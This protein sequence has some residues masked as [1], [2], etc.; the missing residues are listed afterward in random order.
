MS[1]ARCWLVGLAAVALLLQAAPAQ[2]CGGGVAR[3]FVGI[4]GQRV[5]FSV[6]K[7]STEAVLEL[8]VPE[9]PGDWG[10][11]LPV[12]VEPTLDPDPVPTSEID[13]FDAFTQV[14][15]ESD[16]YGGCGCGAGAGDPGGD[17]KGVRASEP[18]DIG[19]VTATVLAAD[20][21][22]SLTAWLDENGFVVPAEEQPIVDEYVTTQ[23]RFVVFKRSQASEPGSASRVGVHMTLPGDH[24]MYPLRISR[25][26][27]AP[28]L[29]ITLWIAASEPVAP[30][31]P[32]VL[33]EADDLLK[34]TDPYRTAVV[35]AVADAGGHAFVREGLFDRDTLAEQDGVYD[36]FYYTSVLGPRLAALLDPG[37]RITRFSTVIDRTQL[38][39]DAMFEAAPE[40]ASASML[41]PLPRG[42]DLTPWLLGLGVVAGWLRACGA[43]FVTRGLG[44]RR[45]P[46]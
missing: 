18:V 11:I 38:D 15:H 33:L 3:E 27:A 41:A 45:E 30:A 39:T 13:R 35:R 12:P 17:S 24:R 25:V 44:G 16:A 22:S 46:R 1:G 28:E 8:S 43:R 14:A 6:R 31:D 19:P 20:D 4:S 9:A 5:L 21:G 10:V 34:E 2:A 23:T 7:D 37:Q 40:P 29:A 26:G 36:G 32:F 42:F